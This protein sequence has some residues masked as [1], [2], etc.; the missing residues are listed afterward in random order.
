MNAQAGDTV[1][2]GSKVLAVG[3]SEGKVYQV[4]GKPVR[5]ERVETVYG[6]SNGYRF[7]YEQTGKT[8]QIYVY[9]GRVSHIEEIFD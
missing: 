8:I 5:R 3:D 1:R 7:D 4:A 6:A 2:I 9:N